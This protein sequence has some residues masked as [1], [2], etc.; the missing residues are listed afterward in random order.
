MIE[1]FGKGWSGPKPKAK[2]VKHIP[3][4][5]PGLPE[6]PCATVAMSDPQAPSG[7]ASIPPFT[8]PTPRIARENLFNGKIVLYMVVLLVV[9]YHHEQ[10]ID[11]PQMRLRMGS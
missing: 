11:V 4:A 9:N 7:K 8:H 5:I 10:I 3:Y 2:R 1:N 6:T